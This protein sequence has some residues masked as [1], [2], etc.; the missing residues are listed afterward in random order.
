[1]KVLVVG[2]GGRE[3]ALVW[4]LARDPDV[5]EV[6][7]APGNVGIARE[8]R[9]IPVAT[10]DAEA[11]AAVVEDEL[12]DLTVVGPEAP[13]I[14]GLADELRRRGLPVF[15]PTAAGA[16][17]E[18]SKAWTKA[19]C[20][21]HGIP[22]AG[23]RAVTTMQ[24]GLDA[25]DAFGPPYV[26]KADGLAA[27]KGVVIAE[28]RADAVD[29]LEACLVRGAFGEAGATVLVEEHLTGRE[30]SA[31]ALT[32]GSRSVP[33]AMAQDF[34]RVRD[35]D[36]GPNTGGMGAYSPVPFVGAAIAERI[37]SDVLART[38]E[39]L[40]AEGID[41]RGVLYA[42]LML[43]PDGPRL[44]EYN[45]R[46]G[47]PETQVLMPR[48][49]SGLGRAL[50]ACAEGG[51]GEAA[52]PL[53]DGACVTVVAASGGYPGPYPTGIEIS[54]L[55]EAAA[56]E[57]AVVFHAGTAE[58]QGRVVTSGGRVLAVSGRGDTIGEAR[59]TAY[60]ALSCIAFEGMQHRRDIAQAATEE[61]RG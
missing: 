34:K 14:A 12:V 25:L 46:F 59:A 21:R 36:A 53:D 7:A 58:R 40:H 41:Y 29:A 11:L 47:D 35:G 2:G 55:D 10:E 60:E 57:D 48:I 42:G 13:L 3:H 39:A 17:L 15:G 8:L 27:G 16:R 31:F 19:L 33:L 32:D 24:A 51:L 18:G 38:A 50:L 22:A 49:S 30:V 56:I 23:S 54:G 9:C 26:V 28:D 4:R 1:M 5:G 52:V 44:L 43:T 45:C 37:W 61:E 20:E 6:L